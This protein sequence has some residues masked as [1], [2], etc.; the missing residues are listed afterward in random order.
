MHTKAP[1]IGK[2]SLDEGGHLPIIPDASTVRYP[3]AG[4]WSTPRQSE[5]DA[6]VMKI[7]VVDDEVN[8]RTAL[9]GLI[10]RWGYQVRSAANGAD[11]LAELRNFDAD[12]II[13]D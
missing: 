11:A 13:T 4:R 12:V 6:D 1:E 5:A 3:E 8:Q 10:T 9:A 2:N 7:L